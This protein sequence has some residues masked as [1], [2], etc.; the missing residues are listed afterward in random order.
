MKVVIAGESPFV[1]EIGQ[2]C[3]EAG[4]DTVMYLVEDFQAAMHSG[5]AMPDAAHADIAIEIHNESA[6]AKEELLSGLGTIVPPTALIVTSALASSVTQA[7]SWVPN[8]ERVVGFAVIPPLRHNGLVEIAAGL[9]THPDY[10]QKTIDF[11]QTLDQ[12]PVQV[13]D[14]PGL[15]RA[16]TICC[17]INEA[18]SALLE[19]VASAEDIDKGMKLGTNYPYGPLEWADYFGLDTVLGIL[20]GL[21]DE[22]GEDRYR[23]SPLIR[24]MVQA[25]KLG[26]KSGEGFYLYK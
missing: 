11:C 5:W 17:L 24:R 14:G 15:V 21:F 8:P 20:T 2:L 26:R 10:L 4:H 12:E 3:T 18:A 25:G 23:V 7:A 1:R 6:S 13:A 22:W 19:G 9:R 16:R